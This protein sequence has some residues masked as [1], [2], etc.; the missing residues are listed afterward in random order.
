MFVL[1]VIAVV[2]E[3]KMSRTMRSWSWLLQQPCCSHHKWFAS[4]W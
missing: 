4:E 3:V 1:F 2:F